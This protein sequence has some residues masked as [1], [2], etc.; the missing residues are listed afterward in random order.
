MRAS[1]ISIARWLALAPIAYPFS[2][3]TNSRPKT[4]R[5]ASRIQLVATCSNWV[6]SFSRTL[7]T[8]TRGRKNHESAYPGGGPRGR[9]SLHPRLFASDD[10]TR[11]PL[12]RF[13]H[14]TRLGHSGRASTRH[15]PHLHA[16]RYHLRGASSLGPASWC[17]AHGAR[18]VARHRGIRPWLG[19]DSGQ[20]TGTGDRVNPYEIPIGER[21]EDAPECERGHGLSWADRNQNCPCD[22]CS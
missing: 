6:I 19:S 17:P 9:R 5:R 13:R 3:H 18:V 1:S 10:C 2:S 8:W 4:A 20:A 21:S 16:G 14:G 11:A 15:R 12:C 7:S 22:A